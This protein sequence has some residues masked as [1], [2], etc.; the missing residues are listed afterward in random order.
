LKEYPNTVSLSAHTHYQRQVMFGKEE[1]WKQEKPHHHYN[2][3]TTSGD[4]YSGVLNEEGIPVSTMRDGTPKGYAFMDFDGNQYSIRYKVAGKD[5]EY[6]VEI[7]A[8]KALRKDVRTTSGIFAN[9]FMG[10]PTDSVKVRID[11]GP[12]QKMSYQPAHDPKYLVDMFMWDTEEE[13][14][15]GRRPSNP[16]LNHHLWRINAPV[17]LEVGEHTIEVEATDR[18]GKKHTSTK[19]FN[20]ID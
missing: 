18:Y 12:W 8:P 13:L 7:F 4:W 19:T 10:S 16:Q 9:F 14:P 3:G 17:N 11:R 2:V 20:I 5:P 1:G 15:Q 6:Q